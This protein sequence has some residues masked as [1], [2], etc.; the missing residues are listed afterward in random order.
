LFT[1]PVSI[2][3]QRP[4]DLFAHDDYDKSG[5]QGY[6]RGL[7]AVIFKANQRA[8][9]NPL[10]DLVDRAQRHQEPLARAN[11]ISEAIEDLGFEPHVFEDP[12]DQSLKARA[13]DIVELVGRDH[14]DAGEEKGSFVGGSRNA[15]LNAAAG[16]ADLVNNVPVRCDGRMV[17]ATAQDVQLAARNAL[18]A[19][20]R[21][22]SGGI[23]DASSSCRSSTQMQTLGADLIKSSEP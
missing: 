5:P 4:S 12:V 19:A 1:G 6:Q 2:R 20:K 17:R 15:S 10:D 14:V 22:C 13:V 9:A 11:R 16:D 23:P 8:V 21:S 3:A 7:R 18:T